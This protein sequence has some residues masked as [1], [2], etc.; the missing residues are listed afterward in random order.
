MP[1]RPR[2]Q[3]VSGGL[4]RP[5]GLGS[6]L[7]A[8]QPASAL[9]RDARGR[10]VGRGVP[11][12][13]V[14]DL[15]R[16][17]TQHWDHTADRAEPV[18]DPATPDS[19]GR[20]AYHVVCVDGRNRSLEVGDHHGAGTNVLPR[21]RD[22]RRSRCA[23]L[24]GAGARVSDRAQRPRVSRTCAALPP[25]ASDGAGNRRGQRTRDG[26]CDSRSRGWDRSVRAPLATGGAVPAGV[27]GPAHPV[28]LAGEPLHRARAL[29]RSSRRA[30][31]ERV[32]DATV[33]GKL[34]VS[35]RARPGVR[36]CDQRGGPH[37]KNDPDPCELRTR[38]HAALAQLRTPVSSEL[39]RSR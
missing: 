21:R 29:S 10:T 26:A 14:S 9:D 30:D 35:H 36:P 34:G 12:R 28:A 11:R 27:C 32:A 3:S 22:L 33:R 5:R 17:Y 15:R 39:L 2:G 16:P 24:L 13:S 31:R 20:H 4:G 25:A 19:L 1:R 8:V 7:C 23:V 37:R 38:C 6:S 18:L